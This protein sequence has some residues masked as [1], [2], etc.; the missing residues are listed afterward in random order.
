MYKEQ[1]TLYG[2]GVKEK[3]GKYYD[4]LQA[5]LHYLHFDL[6]DERAVTDELIQE[7][8]NKYTGIVRDI[9]DRRFHANM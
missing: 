3:Y 1:L 4:N 5:R 8:T 6:V 2:L 7:V 9:E